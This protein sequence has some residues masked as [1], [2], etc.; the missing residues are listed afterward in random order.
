MPQIS[1]VVPVYN[2][3]Q[4][5]R[6]CIDSILQQTFND[7][8]L[9]L[10]DDGSPD[11]CPQIC[12]EY[13]LKDRR[14][15]VIHKKNG[16]L[17]DARNA[18][19]DVAEGEY[20]TFIDS[21][22]LVSS[23][24]LMCLYNE[25]KANNADVSCCHFVTFEEDSEIEYRE[26]NAYPSVIMTGRE[27]CMRLYCIGEIVPIMSCGKMYRLELFKE[28]RFPV[29]KIHEDDATTPKVLFLA[30][31]VV[32]MPEARI[33]FYRQRKGSII[34]SRT[35]TQRFDGMWARKS[36]SLYF[37]QNGDKELSKLAHEY[38]LLGAAEAV[39]FA[40]KEKHTELIPKEYRMS[41]WR[42]LMIIIKNE[43]DDVAQWYIS[44]NHPK[45]I[46]IHAYYVKIKKTLAKLK[47]DSKLII[48][49]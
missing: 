41:E 29:G 26:I 49:I 19:I 25:A 45:L 40:N 48:N 14:V 28:I 4:Y 24:Y 36:C 30:K 21:D 13:A 39:V 35:L 34:E 16:G 32:V 31:N 46:R 17:S 20:I 6:Q 43:R 18:G 1:V 38:E 12:E 33:Y 7:F 42:A 10:V 27:A 5:I 3:E 8:E 44:L 2:V 11:F 22:D 47:K 9:I 37:A 15:R 23:D